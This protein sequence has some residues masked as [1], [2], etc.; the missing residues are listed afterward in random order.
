MF[1]LR[2]R[3]QL[4]IFVILQVGLLLALAGFYLQWQLQRLVEREL[5][6]RLVTLA[7]LAAQTT[8]KMAEIW[9]VTSLLPGDEQ[10]RRMNE[11]RNELLPIV[12][13]AGLS[14]LVIFDPAR[15]IFFDS[16]NEL[17]IG[18]EYVRLRFDAPEIAK[19]FAGEAASAK[20]FTDVHGQPFKAAYAPLRESGRIRAIVGVE[21]SA[22]S[23]QA[24]AETR[25][26]LWTIGVIGLFITS[27]TGVYFARRITQ[28]LERLRQMAAAIGAGQSPSFL[29]VTGNEEVTFLA[30]T[31]EEMRWAIT[32][33][34]QN[35]RMMLSGV[36]HE[37][38]NPL[39]GIELFA[40]LLEKD[41]PES[42]Q[43]QVQKI[44]QEVRHLKSIVQDFLEYARPEESRRQRI[45]L[46]ALINDVREALGELAN[47][48]DWKGEIPRALA[49]EA[50]YSQT[51]RILLNLLRNAIEAMNGQGN[52][53]I[54]AQ[55]QK[56]HVAISIYD[57]G[58]GVPAELTGKIF[59]PFF[60][61]KAQ[62]SGLGLA[63]V[64]RLAEQNNGR[65][66]LVPSE[67][68]AHFRLFLPVAG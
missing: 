11:L 68:G 23:L 6:G 38:R 7:K 36:A 14:R 28:P 63:L 50:D 22:E 26:V 54:V 57:S 32:R 2:I 44:L 24:V 27:I 45:E 47:G 55:E 43:P 19:A 46:S 9:P 34:E 16:R 18:Q 56:Q 15:T 20:L 53:H 39:G 1:P 29:N 30:K 25:R 13:Q 51:R 64:Q 52:I 8:E 40:G 12:R 10:S 48:I 33:R 49:V 41:V 35:L 62:G 4:I 31:L 67:K 42:L 37:I 58:P 5:G 17:T 65:I 3:T 59:E 66:E 60:T 21:G 61:T